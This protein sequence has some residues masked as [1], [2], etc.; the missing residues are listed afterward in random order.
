MREN[1]RTDTTKLIVGFR[2]FVKV[3]EKG[4]TLIANPTTEKIKNTEIMNHYRCMT[5][6]VV[7]L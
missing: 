4:N 1:G 3:S 7:T 2:N 6:W 5:F